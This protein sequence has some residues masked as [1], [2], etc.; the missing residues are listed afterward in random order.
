MTSNAA[1]L[2]A[3]KHYFA[4]TTIML[5]LSGQALTANDP[6]VLRFATVGDSRTR[7]EDPDPSTLPLSAQDRIWLQNSKALG[8]IL[9][10]VRAQQ[11]QL[12]FFNGDMI[13][14]YGKA[15]V[16]QDTSSVQAIVNSDLVQTY[17]QYA[18]WR[19]MVADAIETGTY[20]V[21]VM[22][23]H[24]SQWKAAG[25]L[26]QPENEDAWRANM[27]DLIIDARRMQQATGIEPTFINT[28]NN[29]ALDRLPSDQSQLSYSFD[30]RDSHFAV[31]NTDPTGA[32]SH[33][34]SQWLEADLAAAQAR[35]AKHL[36]VFGHKPAYTYYYSKDGAEPLPTSPS[37]LSIDPAA[38]D[39]FWQVIERHAATY[40]CGHQHIFNIS[41]HG[42]AW[43]VLVGS[44]GSP[45][46]AKIGEPLR[47]ASDRYYAWAT[48]SIH[49]SGAV[50]VTA[51]GFD[52][53]FGATH[54][55][56]T[57]KLAAA[58]SASAH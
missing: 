40:L 25:K 51:Y 42:K 38:R 27:G 58:T 16:P 56:R 54:K 19:G 20:V 30:L 50:E 21:P 18:Y 53:H 5:L 14:G 22:G 35:G 33:A 55:L 36:F 1:T 7:H 28:R 39:E 11:A 23:N 4:L 17:R 52:E 24:E 13:N 15:V 43:Q 8:R 26:A 31:M 29:A 10:G 46:E 9:R 45:F 34:P 57:I 47:A 44:G 3:M 49:A 6:V 48:V 32:D 12:L 37:G 2:E 41:K